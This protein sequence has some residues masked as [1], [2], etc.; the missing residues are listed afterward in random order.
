MHFAGSAHVIESPLL[1]SGCSAGFAT[2]CCGFRLVTI[3]RRRRHYTFEVGMGAS[4]LHNIYHI[5]RL[6]PFT[7]DATEGTAVADEVA[8]DSTDPS[9]GHRGTA[10]ARRSRWSV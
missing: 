6:R 2:V 1:S 3:V 10:E 9:A 8:P 5:S 4:R 7:G